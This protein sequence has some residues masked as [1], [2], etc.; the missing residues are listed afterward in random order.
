M[1][2]T[3]YM[4]EAV[5]NTFQFVIV[6]KY[7]HPMNEKVLGKTPKINK[8]INSQFAFLFPVTTTGLLLIISIVENIPRS[9]WHEE[10]L[11]DLFDHIVDLVQIQKP[12]RRDTDLCNKAWSTFLEYDQNGG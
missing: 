3:W 5:Q 10:W 9:F 2:T 8:N 4:V 6:N 11:K 7:F 12:Y 1:S